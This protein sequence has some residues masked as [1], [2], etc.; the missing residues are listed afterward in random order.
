MGGVGH[1]SGTV[2]FRCHPDG[3]VSFVLGEA[4]LKRPSIHGV[5]I[6]EPDGHREVFGVAQD[7]LGPA[8]VPHPAG[9]FVQA[10]QVGNER[11]VER[12]VEA[13]VG[14]GNVLELYAGSGNFTIPLAQAGHSVRAVEIDREAV[15]RLN[16]ELSHRGLSP[17]SSAVAGSADSI[18]AGDWDVLIMDPPRSGARRIVEQCTRIRS[19]KRIV[20][21]SCHPASFIRDIGILHSHDWHVLSVEPFDLFPHTGHGEVLGIFERV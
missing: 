6:I 2:E 21:V 17:H 11:L 12:V 20:Y 13:C 3:Q 18:P 4:L 14:Y 9:S 5:V 10:H 16:R 1:Q 7:I 19:L 8:E 15:E